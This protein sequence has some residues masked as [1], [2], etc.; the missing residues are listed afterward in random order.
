MNFR[1]FALI[2]VAVIFVITAF[3]VVETENNL[4]EIRQLRA[5]NVR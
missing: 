5:A 2:V 1:K 3:A 4:T